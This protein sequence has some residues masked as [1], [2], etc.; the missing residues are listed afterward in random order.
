[1]TFLEP[2]SAFA[3]SLRRGDSE[4]DKSGSEIREEIDVEQENFDTHGLREISEGEG[5]FYDAYKDEFDDLAETVPGANTFV[6]LMKK[7]DYHGGEFDC[8]RFDVMCHIVNFVFITGTSVIN[9]LVAP[10]SKLAIEPEEIMNDDT[11]NTFLGYFETF[12]RSLLAVF[13][14]F[15]IMKIYLFRLSNHSDTINVMNEKIVKIFAA[16]VLLFCYEYFFRFI[17]SIQYRVNYG[18]FGYVGNT[19]EVT[20]NMMLNLLLTPNGVMFMLMVI[21]FAILLLVLFFQMTYTFA[22]IALFYIVGPV[23]VVTMVNDEYNMFSMWLKTIIGRFL[24]LALQGLS[25]VLC[26]SFASKIDWIFNDFSAIENSFSKII[27]L[28]FLV[29]GISIPGLLKDFGNSSGA[30]R[31][32]MSAGQSVTRV[33]TRRR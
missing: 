31:G 8:G 17:L 5:G 24:T 30:G 7:Y 26:F 6:E 18:I 9:F 15:Q 32:V 21:V 2:Y 16:G 29:V 11:L 25:V 12:T 10:M 27:A 33:I 19:N 13:I 22:M 3:D 1:M 23:A 20:S 28:S 4:I 14:L